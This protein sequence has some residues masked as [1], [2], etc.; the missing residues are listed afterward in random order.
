[1]RD[2]EI[3]L[4]PFAP[5]DAEAIEAMLAEPDVKRWRMPTTTASTGG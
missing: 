5:A 3:E 1:M 4:R 2:G